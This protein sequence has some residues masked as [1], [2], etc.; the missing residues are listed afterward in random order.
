MEEKQIKN[1]LKE[2][3][4]KFGILI[5]LIVL[6]SGVALY[7]NNKNRLAEQERLDRIT[8]E[9]KTKTE[10]EK[11]RADQEQA[12]LLEQQKKEEQKQLAN[13][14]TTAKN[15]RISSQIIEF[16]DV[17][18]GKIV[19]ADI[20]CSVLANYNNVMQYGGTDIKTAFPD[21]PE[22]YKNKCSSAYSPLIFLRNKLI[23][24]PELQ[25]LRK[26]LTDY[27]DAVKGLATYALDGGY[28]AQ[29]I[30]KYS[31][32]FDKFRLNA[33]EE[34]SRLQRLYNVKPQY[35]GQ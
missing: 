35:T 6:V 27:L 4:F 23:A 7:L 16:E 19:N 12:Q 15:A 32:D 11:A 28:S 13:Q 29:I 21:S 26:I 18:E 33:R 8:S 17:L 20:N 10:D 30:D 22:T 5:V 9:A 34:L 24:E 31:A 14:A 3:W 1:W 25:G 2:N